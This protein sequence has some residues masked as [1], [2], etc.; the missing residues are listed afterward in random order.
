MDAL[1]DRLLLSQ[2]PNLLLDINPG[3]ADSSPRQFTPV[4]NQVFFSANNG[5]HGAELWVSNGT[6]AGTSLV[7][8]INPGVTGSKPTNLTNLNGTLFFTANDGT[9]GVQL[10]ESNG[11]A[12]GTFLF[13]DINPGVANGGPYSLANVN[14][15]LFFA[16]NDGT[17]GSELWVSN[18]AAAGTFLVTDI[19]P[20]AIS[21]GSLTNMN[22]T[23][24]FT[25]NGGTPT[26]QLW[27]SNGTSA[28]TFPLPAVGTQY[29]TNVNGTL[30]FR[31]EDPTHLAELW[32][33]NGT[34]AGTFLVKDINP[35][36][37]NS[38]PQYLTNVNGTVFFQ[39]NDGSH[40][41]E[42]WES[43]GSASGTFLVKDIVPGAASGYAGQLANVNGTLFFEANDGTHGFELWESN[44]S[45][46]GTVFVAD[47]NPG[48]AS[49]YPFYLTNVNGTV[50]FEANDG[51]DGFELWESN[52]SAAGTLLVGD[53]NVGPG[54]P[55]LTNANGALLFAA[56][57]GTHGVEPWI[58][59]PS[60]STSVSVSP[61]PAGFGQTVT[62]TAT[63]AAVLGFTPTGTVD[64]K[65]GSTD[66]TPGGVTLTAGQATF[67]TSSLALGS[68]TITALYGGDSNFP[69]SSGAGTLL[70]D[71]TTVTSSHNPSAF[72]QP[73]TFTATVSGGGAGTPTGTVDFREGSK[74]LTPGGVS[75]TAGQAAFAIN[76]LAVGS[77]TITAL[78]SGDSQFP[79]S[80]GDDS[81]NP[82]VV[83]TT[84][85]LL[86]IN[87]GSA[88]SGPKFFTQVSNLT[89]FSADDGN[90]GNELWES[91]G[92]AAG[93]FLVKDINPGSGGSGPYFL[94]NVNGT[95]FF[96]ADDGAHGRELWESNG[97][98]AGTFLVKD[99]NPG[100]GGSYA[101]YM[102][103]MNGTLFFSAND[104][105]NGNE[106]WESNGTA[107]GT[108]PVQGT[109]IDPS[110]VAANPRL[111]T[112]VNGILFFNATDSAHGVELWETNGS[113]AGTFLVKDIAPGGGRA[114]NGFPL[115]LTNVN[116]TLFFTADDGAH[117]TEL[118]EST[119]TA[120]GTFL[121][122][123]INP[124]SAASN[125]RS[126]TNVNGTLFFN[127]NDGTHGTQLWESNGSAAG[128]FLVRDIGPSFGSNPGYLTNVNGTLFF[129]ANGANINELW[130]SNGT[131]AGTFLV[132][133]IGPFNFFS[134]GY[135][136]N[137]NGTLFFQANDGT[138]GGE[139]WESNGTASG[140][141]LVQD[142]NPGSGNSYASYLTNGNGELFFSANDGTHGQ[143]PWVVGIKA[144]ATGVSSTPNPSMLGQ[145]VTFT[146]TVG[147]EP[148]APAPTGTVDFKDGST[149]LT[150]GGVSLTAG[151]VS[152]S[153]SSL[154]AGS[155]TITAFYSGDSNSPGSQGDD[156][157]TPQVVHKAADT[158]TVTSSPDPAGLGQ[159]VTFTAMVT[160]AVSFL[161]T[162]TVDF[163]DGSTDLTPGG[164]SLSAGQATFSTS[165][166]TLGSH[167]ITA[168]YGG[169]ANFTG[170]QG[171]DSANPEVVTKNQSSTSLSSSPN[172]SFFGQAVIFTA[173]VQ[174]SGSGGVPTGT[175]D[176]KEGNTDLTPGG[177]SLTAGQAT[178]SIS[179]LAVGSHTITAFYSG[180]AQFLSSQEDDSGKPQVV[181]KDSTSVTLI[182]P[183]APLSGQLVGF[184][185]VVAN[186]SGPFT[187]P[188]GQVQFAVDGTN[189]GPS[190][191]LVGGVAPS[192]PT[193]LLAA[194]S[195]HTIAATYTNS[196]GSF[197]GSSHS[198]IQAVSKDGTKIILIST[199]TT[200]VSGQVVVF[201]AIVNPV[202]PGTGTPTG[203]VDFN[204]G[205]TDLTPGGITMTAGRATFSNSS[206][207]LG[208][209]T[210]TATYG[211]DANFTD[212]SGNDASAP[213]VVNKASTRT[214]M[215]AFPDPSVLGQVV[216]F[217][218]AVIALAPSQGTPTGTVTF[219][220]GATTIGSV[221]VNNVGRATFTAASLS[222]GNH[223]INAN[224]GGDAKFLTS[225]YS[226]FGQ[227]VQQDAT[228]ATV[229]ASTNPA[230]VGTTIT[231]T[232]TVQASSPG[233]G[234]PT[235]TVTFLDITTTLGTG[236]LN[237][238][239]K[240][241]FTTSALALGTH[242]IKATYAGDNNFLA[243]ASLTL[244]ET[245]KSSAAALTSV[246]A[247]STMAPSGSSVLAPKLLKD[248]NPG[249]ADSI[250]FNPLTLNSPVFFQANNL[251]YFAVN[252]GTHGVE[253]WASNGTTAG[254]FLV[255][256]IN[257]GSA[258]SY[259]AY[260]TNVN[261]T[262]F[263]SAN[264]GTHGAQLWTSNGTA[265]G[266]FMV[267]DVN[268][269]SGGLSPQFLTNV[270]GTL[271][272]A[273]NDG[274]H[275]KQLW[276][277]NGTASGTAMVADINGTAGSDPAGLTNVNGTAFF[278]ANDGTHGVELWE[279]NGS[280]AGTRLVADINPGSGNS[281]PAYL[282]NVNGTLFFNAVDGTNG[283]E[284]WESNGS[285]PGTFLVKDINPGP[286]DSTPA[287]MTN[288]SGTLFFSANDGNAEELW[289]SNGSAAGTFLLQDINPGS[290][291]SYPISLANVNGTLFFEADDGIHGRELW[292]SNGSAAGTFLV[293]DINP[294]GGSYPY[295][296]T[297]VNGTLF[298]DAVDGN[299]LHGFQLWA[300]NGSAEGTFLVKD[301][302]N[303]GSFFGGSYP[304]A[305]ANVNGAL[306]FMADD[307]THGNEPWILIPSS[308][309]VSSSPNPTLV[310]QTVTFTATVGEI[311]NLTPTGTVDFKD[312]S[313]DLTPGGVSLTAGQAT[314]TTS[315]LAAGS[316][317]ITALYSG[318]G[319]FPASS[320]AAT[321]NVRTTPTTTLT[322]SPNPLALGQPVTFTAT[323]TSGAAGTPTGTVDFMEGSTDL[324][325]GGVILTAGQA[326]FSIS[327]L[328]VGSH[329]VTALYSGDANFA[330]SQ[331]DDSANPQVVQK[332]STS[333]TVLVSPSTL[334]SGQPA[335]FVAVVANTSSSFGPPTGQIQFAV[336]GTNLGIPVTL[337]NG[338]AF[339]LSTSLLA[340]GSPHTISATYTN[341]DGNFVGSGN[342]VTQAVAKDG[343]RT[344][345]IS[346]PT[347][348]VS[349]QVVNFTAV[350]NPMA[351]GRGT[352]TGTVDFKEGATDLTPGGISLSAGRAFFST[353][354]LG[355]GSHTI[356]AS[357]G[358]DASFTGS[359]GN[360][361]NS[362][363]VNQAS[364]R[365]VMTAF[366][367]P[368]VF[369]QMVSFT[370]AVIALAPSQGT[371]TG[372][373]TFTDGA[374]PIGTVTV[375]NVGRATF[376][377]SSLS[378]GN[379]AINAN[380]GGD[381]K[382]KVS[383]YM[384]FGETVQK[385]STMATVT[386]SA[387]P[388]VIG[389]TITFTATIQASSPGAGTPTGTVTFLDITTTL[390]TGT[391]N[392]AG[393]ATFT[394]SALAL[395][396]HAITANYSGD[397]NFLAGASATLAETIKSSTAASS[398]LAFAA[399]HPT[400][401]VSGTASTQ[402]TPQTQAV[403]G[404]TLAQSSAAAPSAATLNPSQLDSYF[405]AVTTGSAARRFAQLATP[406]RDPADW[407]ED[408]V[409]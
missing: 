21:A 73:A 232:A 148:G 45:A 140:T 104:G 379:H 334:V 86:D 272:F 105:T 75:L 328:A 98:A 18:G 269:A 179:S 56:N 255:K 231:F 293:K 173:K 342:S 352:P 143:E 280:A 175:V 53:I 191:T 43:N 66:L 182:G 15:S 168:V 237:A 346:T 287:N 28:G 109:G 12:A 114:G 26:A 85:L 224:Y 195:P 296:L 158:P 163:K 151:H 96:R 390:G 222:R 355:L 24:F 34:N 307:H 350:V 223:A 81:A 219:T 187:S 166:L 63:V 354:S 131:A 144:T 39:A 261:G 401:P 260:L 220:D 90:H 405:A 10:W 91:N 347:N 254:T 305:L 349:G 92:S 93:T 291:Q 238:A 7:A 186:T 9:D 362:L 388:A 52:G 383:S 170:S 169:D 157:G 284:L 76:T 100:T 262:L 339:R 299:Q 274:S 286:A 315:T 176:F 308:T 137:V 318:D 134:T 332:D 214:V 108:F 6:A 206:L 331:G 212:N 41:K 142:I 160:H 112:N 218:V 213:E 88:R 162:G 304:A 368:S 167:T 71:P 54:Y 336:D 3:T 394:T 210:L 372:T 275:G 253:L 205:G 380:Y 246:R 202:A 174:A 165:S 129:R 37:A 338:V 216:S 312:G 241:T 259:P 136:T 184:V 295:S 33:S 197:I 361:I 196:D 46:A 153:T 329:T 94:A 31:A 36:A 320:D 360:D 48:S 99:I 389:T 128:T 180:S 133:E 345:L 375:N 324:T 72:G 113:A 20:G 403:K 301:I 68:H 317:T 277:S 327:T 204:E 385:D 57:D 64:F 392:A 358:G 258:S 377:T 35:G 404:T 127:A 135:P 240:A 365:T 172:P 51:S 146:A 225:A 340:A 294:A 139:L 8:D 120:A 156:S 161:P 150:P 118:W 192:L 242:A 398:A 61:N 194:G 126:L 323:L 303:Q 395:G 177:V 370:V 337:Q 234:L 236:T 95:L 4:N 110:L 263:F 87:P 316:H 79:P 171:D 387:N 193:R 326:T 203:L 67:N 42:L 386:A 256:D 152:F 122:L 40:G 29:L 348:A 248:I 229:T 393:Q 107:S 292:E 298:F 62:F 74:D 233:S 227:P 141:F 384:G 44:G 266:T 11:T 19:N 359:S 281:Y 188:T 226:N 402:A 341:S 80:Q 371:P 279:S 302:F 397:N 288:V 155:H 211:G 181:Q 364:T 215:T 55:F 30:F 121:V 123:D 83:T 13:Q 69:A 278:S 70:V 59:I 309:S 25:A 408:P 376:T 314:F 201:T 396:T 344:I 374:T 250:P 300:S 89:F 367:D 391:L 407:L 138:H 382:F 159:A 164:V 363:V 270:N 311:I 78:Y 154:A 267:S 235:G 283:H 1:E 378:L 125:P 245:V 366:P 50:F 399:L 343:T 5:M 290:A 101:E 49:S 199:P 208:N 190:V 244:A 406:R 178:F 217:T 310:G 325:P 97:T 330:P 243:S 249:L 230:V 239:G 183:S 381:A 117:G 268:P 14:G 82:Q 409:L 369:G 297:N 124:G 185:A 103:N 257:P 77:H 200:A 16:A 351:P 22:G 115:D 119:G 58:L 265:A 335:E 271:F 27:E 373:V 252:D 47:I 322:S 306:F 353:S 356:T 189:L 23:L 147:V 357:Y 319:N 209:H 38:S 207:A 111:F 313:T 2:T 228:T 400:D 84:G 32:E 65:E 106:I 247:L 132:S 145:T 102:T 285:A 149:D 17:G 333:V 198:M 221:T 130:A 289:E 116:G 276:E 60:S 282:T 321:Q 251:V 264:D 273:A